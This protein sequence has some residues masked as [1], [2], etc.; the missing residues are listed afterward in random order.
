MKNLL[1]TGKFLLVG[2]ALALSNNS[3][4]N[5]DETLYSQLDLAGSLKTDDQFIATLGAAYTGLYGFMNHGNI[6][7][8][9][10][11]GSDEMII[12]IRGSDWGDG[13]QWERVKR[14]A[15]APT[16]DVA[17]NIWNFCFNGVGTCNR[18]IET[19]SENN[20]TKAAPFVSE[21]KVLR[22]LYY[23]W[24][25]DMFGNVP[26]LTTFKTAEK[27]PATKTRAE[28]YAFLEK[29]LADNVPNL[30]KTVDLSTYARMNYYVGRMIQAK[31]YMNAQV[32]SG[33]AQ[34]A[35]AA[36]AL[37]EIMDA[38][39]Y[40]IE[41][42]FFDCFKTDNLA[43]KETIFA[44]PYDEIKATGFNLPMMTLHYSSQATFK[45]NEQP[46]N[47]YCAVTDFYNSFDNADNRKKVSFIAGPQYAADGVTRILDEGADA[48][49]PDGKPLTYM[50]ELLVANQ[51]EVEVWTKTI[52]QAGVRVGKYEF[53]LGALRDL[54]NDFPV[55]RY[56]DVLLLKAECNLRDAS[57]KRAT[58][59]T[60]DELVGQLRMRATKGAPLPYP[61]AITL[62]ELLKE[63]GREGFAEAWRRQDLIRFGKFA[64]AYQ[65]HPADAKTC[66]NIL[67]IPK[68]QIAA[69]PNLTQNECYK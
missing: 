45:L 16:E 32:Y 6:F 5:L 18:L 40:G 57:T 1:K 9:N 27:T 2:A 59:K 24:L 46:W 15:M 66:M 43:S 8:L 65:F 33:T 36:T 53:K 35:K 56:A 68:P 17:N 34:W 54:S 39:K 7:S 67:P 3:C 37:N 41:P 23:Y 42:N 4:T 60:A 47:G 14:H 21:L 44:I 10:E 11:V 26:I 28:V 51:P 69:N 12:P 19:L 25:L 22:G 61:A 48:N 20:P 13:N 62:D 30:S 64:G 52:R 63:R 49:D 50:P 31:L 29:D 38:N 55:F 58:D